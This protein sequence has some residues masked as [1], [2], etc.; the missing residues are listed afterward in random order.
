MFF[1]LR[2]SGFRSPEMCGNA[3]SCLFELPLWGIKTKSAAEYWT[4]KLLEAANPKYPPI[5]RQEEAR[6]IVFK[7]WIRIIIPIQIIFQSKK[8]EIG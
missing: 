8:N 6:Q 2:F 3:L 7:N 4:K 1:C 5:T